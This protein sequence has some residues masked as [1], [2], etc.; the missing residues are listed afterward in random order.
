M[1]VRVYEMYDA[2]RVRTG[3]KESR[4][5][6]GKTHGPGLANWLKRFGRE[7]EEDAPVAGKVMVVPPSVMAGIWYI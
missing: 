1:L 4:Q 7:V 3:R 5:G 2:H 6:L